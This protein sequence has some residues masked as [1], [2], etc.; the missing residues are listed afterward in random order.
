MSNN[1]TADTTA[2]DAGG[3]VAGPF[4]GYEFVRN[5]GVVLIERREAEGRID[6]LRAKLEAAE[7]EVA[8]IKRL[9]AIVG[10]TES[11]CVG[12]AAMY[13]A[14][15]ASECNAGEIRTTMQGLTSA[16]KPIGDW[17]VIVQRAARTKEAAP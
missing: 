1:T 2:G 15:R 14:A 12:A 5:D 3:T 9:V 6:T 8:S 17:E 4:W 16:G 13:L 7:A 11:R 10:D